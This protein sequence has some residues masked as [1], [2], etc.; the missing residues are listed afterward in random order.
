[1]YDGR[2][3]IMQKATWV[4]FENR[5]FVGAEIHIIVTRGKGTSQE[6]KEEC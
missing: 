1:M 3:I 5:H 2:A 4:V 6:A